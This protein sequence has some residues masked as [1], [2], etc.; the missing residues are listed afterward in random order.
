MANFEKNTAQL[1]AELPTHTFYLGR[2][3]EYGTSKYISRPILAFFW[4]CFC[5]YVYI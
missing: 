4:L 5:I 3:P 1:E 2:L